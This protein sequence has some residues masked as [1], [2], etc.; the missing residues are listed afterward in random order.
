MPAGVQQRIERLDTH[1]VRALAEGL[2][3]R[4]KIWSW[5]PELLAA[6][7]MLLGRQAMWQSLSGDFVP[8]P[9]AALGLGW[10][11]AETL[12]ESIATACFED[13]RVRTVRVRVEK[14]EALTHA[15]SVGIEIERTR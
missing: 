11:P 5:P 8:N 1:L 7:A 9:V 10:R 13:A 6:G 14:L 4:A 2:G 12:A 15:E 3:V